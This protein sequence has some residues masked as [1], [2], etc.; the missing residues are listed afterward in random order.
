MHLLMIRW[1]S[2]FLACLLAGLASLA[3][4][5]HGYDATYDGA[6]L[7]T[8]DG[9]VVEFAIEN[10]HT[11]IVVEVASAR[12][13][14]DT[15]TVE[16]VPATRATQM[17]HPL[18]LTNLKPGDKVRVIGWPARDGSHRL[19]GHRLVQEGGREIM[20]RPAINLPGRRN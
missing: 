10:P 19:G 5:H 3:F 2:G 9:R 6:R 17:N 12:G 1:P 7:I 18:M 16:T 8:L 15:W 14:V 11:R 20:L 13:G 4:A